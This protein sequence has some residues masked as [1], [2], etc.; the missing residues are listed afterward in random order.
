M[1]YHGV[2]WIKPTRIA[3]EGSPFFSVPGGSLGALAD[4]I[5]E[6]PLN[7]RLAGLGCGC[8][9]K[10][11]AGASAALDMNRRESLDG[12]RGSTSGL[13]IF[14]ESG[15]CKTMECAA[16]EFANYAM[17]ESLKIM[18]E[19]KTIGG[20][21]Y[22]GEYSPSYYDQFTPL[23]RRNHALIDEFTTVWSEYMPEEVRQQ[24]SRVLTNTNSTMMAVWNGLYE[25]GTW[26]KLINTVKNLPKWVYEVTVGETGDTVV[27]VGTAVKDTVS[28]AVETIG[29][30]AS[31][32]VSAGKWI[33][34][35]LV[36]AALLAIMPGGR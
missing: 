14:Q 16:I 17:V 29:D 18:E 24:V 30:V 27:K 31:G 33:T 5:T 2:G 28:G 12:M 23:R 8:S 19:A 25:E 22:T 13:G 10:S 7:R 6:V 32:V 9:R 11:N 20:P 26:D 36:A 34:V 21:G 15:S 4:L 1:L 35:A 3:P